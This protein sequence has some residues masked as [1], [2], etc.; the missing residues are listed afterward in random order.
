M[1]RQS[2]SLTPMVLQ[3]LGCQGL[4]VPSAC[5]CRHA[6]WTL[7]KWSRN[8]P[9]S[10]SSKQGVQVQA[11]LLERHLLCCQ[12][13]TS[14]S[15]SAAEA[16]CPALNSPAVQPETQGL[17]QCSSSL[18]HAISIPQS[19]CRSPV[20]A[21]LP[22]LQMLLWCLLAMASPTWVAMEQPGCPLSPGAVSVL[23]CGACPVLALSC[24]QQLAGLAILLQNDAGIVLT[25][26]WGR[27]VP[28]HSDTKQAVQLSESND[29]AMSSLDNGATGPSEFL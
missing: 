11:P 12:V 27:H 28:R 22:N 18:T 25:T 1:T 9:P 19:G 20:T 2:G 26:Y 17:L 7:I 8:K 23:A 21:L 5:S 15:H 6:F 24:V 4:A 29:C 16:A 3:S 14:H 13:W 10:P